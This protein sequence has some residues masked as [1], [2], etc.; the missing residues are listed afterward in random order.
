MVIKIS[1]V[2]HAQATDILGGGANATATFGGGGS[3]S[4]LT[5]S[6]T[7]STS[8]AAVDG[9]TVGTVRCRSRWGSVNFPQERSVR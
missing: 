1:R 5:D 2:C 8:I 6:I 4:G 7:E 9:V 3:A